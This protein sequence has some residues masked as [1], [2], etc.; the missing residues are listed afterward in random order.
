MAKKGLLKIYVIGAI[1]TAFFLPGFVKYQRLKAQNRALEK[2][3]AE[4]GTENRRLS[5]ERKRLETDPVYV[6]RKAR[7]KLGVV[8]KGE[9]VYK[10]S[11]E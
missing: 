7:E 4:L 6:E 11:S 10:T 1:L 2:E 3:I 5:E 9:I 8:K